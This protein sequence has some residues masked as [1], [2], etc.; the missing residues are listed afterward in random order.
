MINKFS[1]S[2][3]GRPESHRFDVSGVPF[4]SCNSLALKDY[5]EVGEELLDTDVVFHRAR[6]NFGK[7]QLGC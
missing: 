2:G 6:F 5:L 3:S 4:L 1:F 7:D